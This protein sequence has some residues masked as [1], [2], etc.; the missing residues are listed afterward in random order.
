[1]HK[2]GANANPLKE[3]DYFLEKYTVPEMEMIHLKF[4]PCFGEGTIEGVQ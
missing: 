3:S 4:K 2:Q 1:M